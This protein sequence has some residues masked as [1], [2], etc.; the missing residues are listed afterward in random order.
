[1]NRKIKLM[2]INLQITVKKKVMK[3]NLCI[4]N[5]TMHYIF[6]TSWSS[7]YNLFALIGR[8]APFS[9]SNIMA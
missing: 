8:K 2:Y 9:H 5:D 6:Q 1:M 7:I 3:Y 4:L